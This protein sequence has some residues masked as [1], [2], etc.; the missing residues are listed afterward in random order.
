[1]SIAF[2]VNVEEAAFPKQGD[3]LPYDFM[4]IDNISK[5]VSYRN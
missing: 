2:P 5:R 3:I 1:V 4:N